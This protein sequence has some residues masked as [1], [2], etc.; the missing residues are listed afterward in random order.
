MHIEPMSALGRKHRLTDKLEGLQ[1]P[2]T[3]QPMRPEKPSS[4]LLLKLRFGSARTASVKPWVC[5]LQ[6]VGASLPSRGSCALRTAY[7]ASVDKSHSCS[8]T[9]S[10]HI[11]QINV[12]EASTETLLDRYTSGTLSLAFC[13]FPSK[14]TGQNQTPAE[15][16]LGRRFSW[17]SMSG[18][19]RLKRAA[20]NLTH[21]RGWSRFSDHTGCHR[22]QPHP[23][24]CPA[25]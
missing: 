14:T 23:T 17:L 22:S 18:R 7:G 12:S 13:V 8:P 19:R 11:H 16:K 20:L 5:P 21:S 6:N 4:P 10:T 24:A 25:S 15:R 1:S 3:R 2:R 9:N